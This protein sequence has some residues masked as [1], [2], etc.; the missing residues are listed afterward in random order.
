MEFVV[1]QKFW[2]SVIFQVKVENFTDFGVTLR[3]QAVEVVSL[4]WASD[5]PRLFKVDSIKAPN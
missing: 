2:F 4:Y 1:F 5:F 3:L